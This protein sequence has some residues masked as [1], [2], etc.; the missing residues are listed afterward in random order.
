MKPQWW[1]NSKGLAQE[2]IK[3]SPSD[4]EALSLSLSLTILLVMIQRTRAGEL[5]IRPAT[6][7]KDWFLWLEN[8][9]DWCISRQ[10]WWGHRAPAYFARM[11]GKEQDVSKQFPGSSESEFS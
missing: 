1:V 11:E 3:V 6:S 5:K 9:Q 4:S 7:E 2:A 10:L 8:I